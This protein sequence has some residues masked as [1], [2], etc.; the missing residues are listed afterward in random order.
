MKFAIV[1]NNKHQRPTKG[2]K[3]FC[4]V[5]GEEVLAKCGNI[6]AHYWSHLANSKCVYKGNKGEWHLSWQNEFPDDWQ[7]VLLINPENGEKIL[8][9]LEV[10]KVLF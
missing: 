4:P 9:M 10:Q 8:R 3:G 7:E 1:G 6:K 2:V 5:C